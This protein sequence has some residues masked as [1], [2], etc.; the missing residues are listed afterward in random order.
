MGRNAPP[1]LQHP[2]PL[3]SASMGHRTTTWM[4][5]W[6]PHGFATSLLFW[7]HCHGVLPTS[8][9]WL[10]NAGS[11]GEAA[12]AAA[13][14]SWLGTTG[15]LWRQFSL[16]LPCANHRLIRFKA[17]LWLLVIN[18]FYIQSII[19]LSFLLPSPRML[20]AAS[21]SLHTLQ[22]MSTKHLLSPHDDTLRKCTLITEP[23]FIY[24]QLYKHRK[25]LL[26]WRFVSLTNE[27]G[28]AKREK[29][30][31]KE[32]KELHQNIKCGR[33]S[34]QCTHGFLAK[35]LERLLYLKPGQNNRSRSVKSMCLTIKN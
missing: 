30:K 31:E 6:F 16:A 2:S 33:I 4:G 20:D 25:V 9:A 5:K 17:Y 19:I 34:S 29:R 3:P 8:K 22:N 35:I 21:S 13:A 15:S 27:G 10:P 26:F 7:N 24:S 1:A 32:I 11:D 12:G 28:G 14:P 23:T 18:Y